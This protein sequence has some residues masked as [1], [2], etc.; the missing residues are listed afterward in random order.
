MIPL[1]AHPWQTS[2]A[3]LRN[4]IGRTL[5]TRNSHRD[6]AAPALVA[7]LCQIMTRCYFH[8]QDGTSLDRDQIGANLRDPDEVHTE[9]RK[10]ARELCALWD[11]LP[12][13]D[14][15][16]MA[17]EVAD[18]SWSNRSGGPLLGSHRV[19]RSE[20]VSRMG[21]HVRAWDSKANR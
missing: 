4:T 11:D 19:N 13:G 18:D 15:N 16:K 6:V 14:L 20:H 5:Q 3:T 12:P 2:S 7:N 8:V 10:V 1:S 9:A 17:I 21:Y